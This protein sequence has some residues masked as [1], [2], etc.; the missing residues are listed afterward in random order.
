MAGSRL[1]DETSALVP[2]RVKKKRKDDPRSMKNMTEIMESSQQDILALLKI[3][4]RSYNPK[5][6]RNHRYREM[7]KLAKTCKTLYVH[8]LSLKGEDGY[9]IKNYDLSELWLISYS[10]RDKLS[11]YQKQFSQLEQYFKNPIYGTLEGISQ[12]KNF[13]DLG[14]LFDDPQP[15][16]GNDMREK[17]CYLTAISL[18]CGFVGCFSMFFI[19]WNIPAVIAFA[20]DEVGTYPITTT[21]PW[22]PD[23]PQH[24]NKFFP[25]LAF[26]LLFGLTVVGV[27]AVLLIML[28]GNIPSLYR[29]PMDML[30]NGQ[31]FAELMS[32]GFDKKAL[33]DLMLKLDQLD[34]YIN[35]MSQASREQSLDKIKHPARNLSLI[36]FYGMF[37]PEKG[38]ARMNQPQVDVESQSLVING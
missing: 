36:E 1:F 14:K 27:A 13:V 10:L 6:D 19:Y 30:R 15:L 21:D 33:S 12:E 38:Q 24:Q 20:K 18:G 17:L 3:V 16:F 37:K 32:S 28:F 8:L 5:T 31:K 2:K 29:L 34:G 23:H 4:L 26:S 9:K 35:T 25:D 11:S 7:F 22:A